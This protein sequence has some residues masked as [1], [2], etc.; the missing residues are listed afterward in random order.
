MLQGGVST[1]DGIEGAFWERFADFC[2]ETCSFAEL[3][4]MSE[5]GT[6]DEVEGVFKALIQTTYPSNPGSNIPT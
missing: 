3:E 4:S 1:G 5:R 6:R 2:E